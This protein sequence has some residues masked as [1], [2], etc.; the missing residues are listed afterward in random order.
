MRPSGQPHPLMLFNSSWFE[1]PISASLPGTSCL[2]Y[3]RVAAQPYGCRLLRCRPASATKCTTMPDA[4][5]GPDL[6]EG[7]ASMRE[8]A[9]LDTAHATGSPIA[10]EGGVLRRRRRP[11][12]AGPRGE[13]MIAA[14]PS[15]AAAAPAASCA[16]CPGPASPSG[17]AVAATAS[18]SASPPPPTGAAA[19]AAGHAS[20]ATPEGAASAAAPAGI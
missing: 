4:G 9:A 2:Q 1:L 16:A 3:I 6:K 5:P 14:C 8:I 18:S 17:P 11:G 13:R 19:P 10:G 20:A 15:S 12:G 7:P